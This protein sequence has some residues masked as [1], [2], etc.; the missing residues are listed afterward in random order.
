MTIWF[1]FIFI[2]LV[3]SFCPSLPVTR[4]NFVNWACRMCLICLFSHLQ[5]EDTVEYFLGLT[6]S[7]IIVLRNKT[8]VGN[9]F[10]WV[11]FIL[12]LSLFLLFEF[13]FYSISF[14]SFFGWMCVGIVSTLP[15]PCS[16]LFLYIVSAS[17]VRHRVTT[18][19]SSIFDDFAKRA[20]F[21]FWLAFGDV[22]SLSR[23]NMA[24][25]A[26]LSVD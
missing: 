7:G 23:A 25:S 16:K 4:E 6:P 9:Y 11:Y 20:I 24:V 21:V 17:I 26:S 3:F 14:C 22:P 13:I 19:G 10:W 1:F 8:K 18:W 12:F 5:G 2:Q 15:Y